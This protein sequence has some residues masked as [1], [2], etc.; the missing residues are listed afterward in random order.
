MMAKKIGLKYVFAG[1]LAFSFV[2]ILLGVFKAYSSNAG[3][4][5]AMGTMSSMVILASKEA[6]RAGMKDSDK[7]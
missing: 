6:Y 2:M 3:I 5:I 1:V 4:A 7:S